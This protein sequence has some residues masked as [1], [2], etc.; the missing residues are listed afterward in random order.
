[1]ESEVGKGAT[2]VIRYRHLLCRTHYALPLSSHQSPVMFPYYD[3]E[4]L[5]EYRASASQLARLREE[6][7][8]CLSDTAQQHVVDLARERLNVLGEKTKEFERLRA[9]LSSQE[10]FLAT[11]GVTVINDHTVSFLVPCGVSRAEILCE[12]EG[13][14]TNRE[15]IWTPILDLWKQT[16]EFKRKAPHAVR[17]TIDGQVSGAN[18]KTRAQQEG[19]VA[20]LGLSVASVEDLAVAFAVFFIATETSLFTWTA[21]EAPR[22]YT[23]QVRAAGSGRALRFEGI[24]LGNVGLDDNHAVH[25]GI[26]AIVSAEECRDGRRR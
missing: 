1:M 17:I 9:E 15:L 5:K 13:L 4:K 8:E 11:C 14:V 7:R 26:A 18:D 16:E 12:A 22:D 10:L 24:G 21:S 6:L 2:V 3:S 25:T 23:Y 20:A 19:I